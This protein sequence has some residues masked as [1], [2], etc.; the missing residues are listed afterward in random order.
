MNANYLGTRSKKCCSVLTYSRI[1]I[2]LGSF[3]RRQFWQF[4]RLHG[5]KGDCV[6]A[7]GFP[8]LFLVAPAVAN[9]FIN[10][11]RFQLA[12]CWKVTVVRPFIKRL[13]I[14]PDGTC[15]A[16]GMAMESV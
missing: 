1:S 15:I 2:D 6:V 7:S 12:P 9:I 3:R 16:T 5:I 4:S 11:L 10:H 14:Q 13:Y 8:S